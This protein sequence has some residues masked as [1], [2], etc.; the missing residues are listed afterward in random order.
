MGDE[1][2][3]GLSVSGRS[4]EVSG[5]VM[6]LRLKLGHFLPGTK[7]EEEK[8]GSGKV[9]VYDVLEETRRSDSVEIIPLYDWT[10][11]CAYRVALNDK[12]LL[13]IQTIFMYPVTILQS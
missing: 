8:R 11:F 3:F 7:E 1:S 9:I 6:C 13:E 10:L 12:S 5:L 4:K 2:S